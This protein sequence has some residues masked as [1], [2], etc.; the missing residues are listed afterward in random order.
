MCETAEIGRRSDR[1]AFEAAI[2]ALNTALLA[3]QRAL[4]DRRLP[5]SSWSRAQRE[6]GKAK[7]LESKCCAHSASAWSRRSRLA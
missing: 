7:R 2:P 6:P 5:L 4:A 3:A 1:T